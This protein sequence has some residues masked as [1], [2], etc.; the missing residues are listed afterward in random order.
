MSEEFY[1]KNQI[2]EELY[3]IR[4]GDCVHEHC[5]PGVVCFVAQKWSKRVFDFALLTEAM[6]Y[7]HVWRKK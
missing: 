1:T 7:K 2:T 5:V 3:G 4:C 6:A